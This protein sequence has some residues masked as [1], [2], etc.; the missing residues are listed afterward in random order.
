MVGVPGT[1]YVGPVPGFLNKPCPSSV[2]M[3]TVSREPEA[4]G[5]MIT[6]MISPE[7][8]PLVR[9]P[10]WSRRH[11]DAGAAWP[12]KDKFNETRQQ[13]IVSARL[14]RADGPLRF[15][16]LLRRAENCYHSFHVQRS[17]GEC[18][19]KGETALPSRRDPASHRYS[20]PNR[21]DAPFPTL[22][23]GDHP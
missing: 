16:D 10:T 18:R 5:A 2:A 3:T 9:K 23:Q 19:L 11:A 7:A 20:R 17:S 22:A 4:A 6:F 1:D 13:G 15:A 14:S 8:A 21:H 12:S